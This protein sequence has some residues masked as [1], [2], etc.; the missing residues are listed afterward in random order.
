MKAARAG[1]NRAAMIAKLHVARKQLAM[2]EESYRALLTRVA[3]VD[4]AARCDERA[5]ARV[6][7]EFE[8][9]GFAPVRN[10]AQ[11]R[12][13]RPHVRKIWAIW[14]DLKPLLDHADDD[15]LRGFVRRQTKS[16]KNPDG[17]A[18]PEWLDPHEAKKVIE[19][20]KGWLARVQR[21]RHAAGGADA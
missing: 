20:L 7:A 5:L 16:M 12:D 21:D 8:R 6:L 4:S 11:R 3:G 17:I 19:G 14:G 1:G 2:E 9:L 18:A 10:R 13:A 15:A